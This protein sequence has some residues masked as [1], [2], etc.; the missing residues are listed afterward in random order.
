MFWSFMSMMM[1]I[2]EDGWVS[3]VARPH[4]NEGGAAY[5]IFFCIY[6]LIG[7]FGILNL[8]TA[9]FIEELVEAQRVE[10]EEQIQRNK[11]KK[12]ESLTE[13]RDLFDQLDSDGSGKLSNDE[14]HGALVTMREPQWESVFDA[15]EMQPETFHALMQ[16]FS[17]AASGADLDGD[18]EMSYEE[19]LNAI[20]EMDDEILRKE[21]WKL[22]SEIAKI[23]ETVRGIYDGMAAIVGVDVAP[24]CL[25]LNNSVDINPEVFQSEMFLQ[26]PIKKSKIANGECTWNKHSLSVLRSMSIEDVAEWISVKA[27]LKSFALIFKKHHITGWVLPHLTE[28]DLKHE[29]GMATIASR[30]KFQIALED[31][32]ITC[33]KIA[34]DELKLKAAAD[35]EANA[36][37][38]TVEAAASGTAENEIQLGMPALKREAAGA[39]TGGDAEEAVDQEPEWV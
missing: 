25:R 26:L 21:Q 12:Y 28:H 29:L 32:R 19:L 30:K 1:C 34:N 5:F 18:G 36:E 22:H 6:V 2:T 14:L 20:A 11:K 17:S 35:A 10:K 13:I 7:T 9:I 3:D 33:A 4:M 24:D 27:K 16:Y 23:K 15:L 38:A 8:L 39:G 37:G 31:L